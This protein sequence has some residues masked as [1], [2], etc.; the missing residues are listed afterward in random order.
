M[1]GCPCAGRDAGRNLCMP[2]LS[3]YGG[4]I[5]C[6]GGPEKLRGSNAAGNRGPR[7]PAEHRP[8]RCAERPAPP[9]APSL[10]GPYMRG[11]TKRGVMLPA[12]FCHLRILSRPEDAFLGECAWCA[13]CWQH[14][15]HL[16]RE[17]ALGVH[18]C[19][20]TACVSPG[21]MLLVCHLPAAPRTVKPNSPFSALPQYENNRSIVHYMAANSAILP[22]T[23][24]Q[25]EGYRQ[26]IHTEAV[27]ASQSFRTKH[28][29]FQMQETSVNHG[30]YQHIAEE[31]LILRN[32]S[33]TRTFARDS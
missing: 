14:H 2:A 8:A 23:E 15:V 13:T 22:D 1:G 5:A 30:R 20:S 24:T 26:Y 28:K 25:N 10:F 31:I 3:H 11:L 32:R 29:R 16:L 17:S 7:S 33:P 6:S 12:A 27:Y 9:R 19:G 18:P 4:S 21:G